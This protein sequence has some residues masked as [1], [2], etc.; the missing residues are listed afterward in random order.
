MPRNPT[1]LTLVQVV[2][3][4]ASSATDALLPPTIRNAVDRTLVDVAC[5]GNGGVT[6]VAERLQV[7]VPAV[8]AWRTLGVPAA[9]RPRLATLVLAPAPRRR[10]AGVE[11]TAA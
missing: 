7:D 5:F 11:P 3:D 9:L 6:G 1:P 10:R 2:G 4:A 8:D